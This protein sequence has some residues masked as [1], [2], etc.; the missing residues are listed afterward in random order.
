[1]KAIISLGVVLAAS[2]AALAQPVT[3]PAS[4]AVRVIRA[5][6]DVRQTV[7]TWVAAEPRCSVAL[8]V[9]IIPTDGGLYLF[10][11]DEHGRIRERI[12]PDAQSAGVLVAS[13]VADD[14]MYVPPPTPQ[15]SPPAAPPDNRD[16]FSV[17]GGGPNSDLATP[18]MTLSSEPADGPP[19]A[20]RSKNMSRWVGLGFL[21]DKSGNSGGLRVDGDIWTHGHYALGAAFSS[22]VNQM[23]A[24]TQYGDGTLDARD[25]KLMATGSHTWQSGRWF[26]RGSVGLGAVHTSVLLS[27][28]FNPTNAYGFYEATGWTGVADAGALVGA[29]LG[30]NWS[31]NVGMLFTLYEQNLHVNDATMQMSQTLDLA[32]RDLETLFYTGLKYRL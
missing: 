26:A 29:E 18:G 23:P 27:I 32:R 15:T 8:D 11:I 21:I 9:R 7:E 17:R 24:Y 12:V 4:C 31:A 13:W 1:M 19:P 22:T 28:D 14:T 16:P 2:Q 25:I 5:P 6:D 10:A 20:P 3:S 30:K